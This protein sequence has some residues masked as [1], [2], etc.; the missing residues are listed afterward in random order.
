VKAAVEAARQKIL[1]G[2]L[3]VCDALNKP[4]ASVC[5]GLAAGG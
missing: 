2:Q 4:D 5:Q 3:E 1:S